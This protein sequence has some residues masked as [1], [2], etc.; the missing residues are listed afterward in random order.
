MTKSKLF[1]ILALIAVP[2]VLAVALGFIFAGKHTADPEPESNTNAPAIH[3]NKP[4]EPA[5]S[6]PTADNDI[7]SNPSDTDVPSEP[8]VS[9]D[10]EV[11]PDNNTGLTPE[12][13]PKP[14]IPDL[15]P[16]DTE[17]DNTTGSDN[18]SP[19]NC[20]ADSHSCN[21]PEAHAFI[22]GLEQEGCPYCDSHSCSSF[23]AVNEWGNPCYTPDK[24]P[25]YDIHKDPVYYCQECD[26]ACG[27]GRSGTC[28]QFVTT[29]ECPICGEPVDSRTCHTCH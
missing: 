28:V 20:P 19:Y 21:S 25:G 12:E 22:Q 4:T 9:I 29:C 8:E 5:G 18:T 24:C 14:V 10:P 6:D 11:I 1:R 15:P 16:V 27:D 2:A 17:D 7:P 3:I 23:Y 26:K 13:P